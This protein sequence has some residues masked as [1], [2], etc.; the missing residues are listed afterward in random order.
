MKWYSKILLVDALMV[1]GDLERSF[2]L[3]YF[4]EIQKSIKISNIFHYFLA[5]N[6]SSSK[7]RYSQI[8]WLIKI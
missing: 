5:S 3:D 6:S 1:T 7:N 8:A 4:G 2:G